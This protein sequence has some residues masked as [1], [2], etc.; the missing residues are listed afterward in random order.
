MVAVWCYDLLRVTPEVDGLLAS[1]YAETVGPYW[2]PERRYVNSAYQ[3]LPFPFASVPAPAMD[4]RM[5]WAVDH[6][7]GYLGTWSAVERYKKE[8][9][10]DPV[11]HIRQDLRSAWGEGVLEVRWPLAM[12]IGRV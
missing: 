10:S 7:I 8:H 5:N 1:F 11:D 4:V 6:F 9:G 2:P 12:R 3:D